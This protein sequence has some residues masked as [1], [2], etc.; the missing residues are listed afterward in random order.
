MKIKK[1]SLLYQ[2]YEICYDEPPINV[3]DYVIGIIRSVLGVISVVSLPFVILGFI[4]LGLISLGHLVL[5]G[6]YW[7]NG[8]GIWE[9]HTAMEL[10]SFFITGVGATGIFVGA[11]FLSCW[12]LAKIMRS[13]VVKIEIIKD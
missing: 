5:K 3:F 4:S 9:S 7:G 8:G 12:S 2:I 10:F 6:R 13:R 1:S 11:I